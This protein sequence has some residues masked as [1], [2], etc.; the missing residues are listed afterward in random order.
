MK[1][2]RKKLRLAALAC[3]AL[4]LFTGCPKVTYIYYAGRAA[5]KNTN[6]S[7]WTIYPD[8]GFDTMLRIERTRGRARLRHAVYYVNNRL[9]YTKNAPPLLTL[10]QASMVIDHVFS[11]MPN[12]DMAVAA[13]E[14]V[15]ICFF[16]ARLRSMWY[17]SNSTPSGA[18]IIEQIPFP[19]DLGA[20]ITSTFKWCAIDLDSNAL[21]HVGFICHGSKQLGG[22]H[23]DDWNS[24]TH[25][26]RDASGAW[27]SEVVYDNGF[28]MGYVD[29]ACYGGKTY[30]C[31]AQCATGGGGKEVVFFFSPQENGAG[32][33]REKAF[34][35]YVYGQ[36][37][38]NILNAKLY[39]TS[40]DLFSIVLFDLNDRS[41]KK[42]VK[43][44]S[45]WATTTLAVLQ[46]DP[47]GSDIEKAYLY[48]QPKDLQVSYI[49]AAKHTLY[50]GA[51]SSG[52]FAF[53][54]IDEAADLAGNTSIV[55][56]RLR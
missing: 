23:S 44:T 45:G 47:S 5:A 41:L 30:L 54:R 42:T 51:F 27:S 35:G 26:T 46:D 52:V 7:E 21:P 13:D 11:E 50:F 15:H 38:S 19:A 37:G 48:R 22:I 18:W 40:P 39:V 25:A 9:L 55:T 24:L 28:P 3:L 6:Q 32:Y 1:K 34:D 17:A 53:S 29:I 14:S 10:P 36:P 56:E 16:D 43:G 33:H 49:N 12:I 8:A 20:I 31:L 4:G 2:M